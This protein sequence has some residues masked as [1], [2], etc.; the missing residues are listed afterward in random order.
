MTRQNFQRRGAPRG[1]RG[2]GLSAIAELLGLATGRFA[3]LP[4]RH[5]DVSPPGR[6]TPLDV[7][8]RGRFASSL[9]IRR[10]TT[11]TS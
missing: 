5:L 8:I 4:I 6:F 10:Q 1:G 9:D 3:T 11:K 7:A 2:R